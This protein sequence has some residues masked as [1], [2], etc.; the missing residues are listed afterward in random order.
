MET[1]DL[2]LNVTPTNPA[3]EFP[4]SVVPPGETLSL[5]ESRDDRSLVL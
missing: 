3:P 5:K 2:V 1:A 4:G